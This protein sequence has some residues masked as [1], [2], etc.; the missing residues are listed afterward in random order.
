MEKYFL[1]SNRLA[2]ISPHDS[3][4]WL[5][6]NDGVMGLRSRITFS[7]YEN[8]ANDT[9]LPELVYSIIVPKPNTQL[10]LKT[11]HMNIINKYYGHPTS[12][13]DVQMM[14][15]PFWSTWAMFKK[16]I[17]QSTVVQYAR[18]IQQHGFTNNSHMEIDDAWATKYGDMQFD[19]TKFPSPTKV[20]SLLLLC[21]YFMN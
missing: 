18:D 17:N 19:G 13:P 7:I 16:D 4:L 6:I 3:T 2:L 11:F 8:F 10:S 14:T 21:F 20:C 5:S 1:S 15:A 9:T 12:P